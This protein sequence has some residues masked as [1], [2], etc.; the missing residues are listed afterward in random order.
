MGS[1]IIDRNGTVLNISSINDNDEMFVTPPKEILHL[2]LPYNKI[3]VRCDYPENIHQENLLKY[4]Y[5]KLVMTSKEKKSPLTLEDVIV[6]AKSF[7]CKGERA[8]SFFIDNAQL[9][10]EQ[11]TKEMLIVSVSYSYST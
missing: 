10:V 4:P 6:A 1:K 3:V 5:I 7:F 2:E 9:T 8:C 11:E